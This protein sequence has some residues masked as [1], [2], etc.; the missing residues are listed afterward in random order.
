MWRGLGLYF[1]DRCIG[2]TEASCWATALSIIFPDDRRAASSRGQR[3]VAIVRK[4]DRLQGKRMR[5]SHVPPKE[6]RAG[7][8][9]AEQAL[10]EMD[11]LHEAARLLQG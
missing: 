7:E 8:F 1:L 6:W 4:A 9:D 5:C 11:A 3:A 10:Q 2:H